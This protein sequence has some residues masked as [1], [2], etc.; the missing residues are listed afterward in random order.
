MFYAWRTGTWK[1]R[2]EE[3]K[4]R[5]MKFFADGSVGVEDSGCMISSDE[6]ATWSKV[7]TPSRS[8]DV[9]PGVLRDGHLVIEAHTF[10]GAELRRSVDGGKTWT[11]VHEKWIRGKNLVGLP[12]TGLFAF[13]EGQFG[14]ITRS[15]DEGASWTMEYTTYDRSMAEPE[16]PKAPPPAPTPSPVP[17]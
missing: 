3:T 13:G 17:E 11:T 10:G 14:W 15:A 7:E 12:T 8:G 6:G 9:C 5:S 16:K 2:Y 1:E 4:V